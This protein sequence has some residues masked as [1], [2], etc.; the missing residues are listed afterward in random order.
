MKRRIR[1]DTINF[2]KYELT[3]EQK[4]MDVLYENMIIDKQ[5]S[6]INNS[7]D[8]LKLIMIQNRNYFRNDLFCCEFS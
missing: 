7:M 4:E 5:I 8:I 2:E 6:F 3:P 1:T